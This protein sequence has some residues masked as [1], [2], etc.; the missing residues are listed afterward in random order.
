MIVFTI[1][2]IISFTI[3]NRLK[4]SFTNMKKDSTEEIEKEVNKV[5]SKHRFYAKK[6]FDSFPNVSF[7]IP[8]G[9]DIRNTIQEL[10]HK[11]KNKMNKKGR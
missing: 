11:E 6:L 9:K 5:L 3:M 1:D 10:L 7:K 4:K 2:C 8:S